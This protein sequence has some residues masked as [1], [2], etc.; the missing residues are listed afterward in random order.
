MTIKASKNN[1][2]SWPHSFLVDNDL[3]AYS[4]LA[5]VDQQTIGILYE[6][7]NT[8]GIVFKTVNL[9]DVLKN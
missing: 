4:D 6:R 1:G 2:I 5:S 9:A 3:A 7:G 8:G